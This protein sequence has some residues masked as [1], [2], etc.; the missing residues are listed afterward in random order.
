MTE[1]FQNGQTL[2]QGLSVKSFLFI[3]T[4]GLKLFYAVVNHES[5]QKSVFVFFFLSLDFLCLYLI[6]CGENIK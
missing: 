6:N 4:A 1:K 2:Q 5:C 3:V